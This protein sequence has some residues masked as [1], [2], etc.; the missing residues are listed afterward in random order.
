MSARSAIVAEAREWIGTP[1][2]HLAH[3]KGVGCDCIGLLRG[4]WEAVNGPL[5]A[6]PPAYTPQ[7]H[8][9]QK[10][11]QLIQVLTTVY[12]FRQLTITCAPP[13]GSVLCFGVGKGPA[14]HAGIMTE[15]GTFI[16][17]IMQANKVEEVPL[18]AHWRARLRAVLDYPGV[19]G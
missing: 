9:H 16:H 6:P 19:E 11:S 3:L 14:H 17:S 12:G 8:L 5:P 2:H 18:G 15:R 10:E 1:Y 4:V 13:V 7:W